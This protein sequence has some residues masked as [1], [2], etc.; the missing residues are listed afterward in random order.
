MFVK[1]GYKESK[2]EGNNNDKIYTGKTMITIL[3]NIFSN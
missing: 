2:K 1:I 3:Y